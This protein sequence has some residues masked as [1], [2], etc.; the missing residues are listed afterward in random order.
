MKVIA[1][2]MHLDPLNQE[3]AESEQAVVEIVRIDKDG[4]NTT[5]TVVKKLNFGPPDRHER[6]TFTDKVVVDWDN[7]ENHHVI[8]VS[9]ENGVEL[10]FTL[11]AQ[12]QTPL[13]RYSVLIAAL[14]LASTYISILL[15]V[16]H[17]TLVSIFGSLV[18]LFFFFSMNRWKIDS[19]RVSAC[20]EWN[21]KVH[22]S[23]HCSMF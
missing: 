18:A 9:S 1:L 23:F 14:I 12:R 4:D 16:I 6:E 20:T 19:I 13:S 5:Q 22:D 15:E 21:W 8:N 7:P 2:T 17:R 10:S 11:A 3:S